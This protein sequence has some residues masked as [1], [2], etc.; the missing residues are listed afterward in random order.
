MDKNNKYFSYWDFAF[1]N[2]KGNVKRLNK[3]YIF[4]I[5]LQIIATFIFWEAAEKVLPSEIRLS[6]DLV[7]KQKIVFSPNSIADYLFIPIWFALSG[8]SFYI[9]NK[10]SSSKP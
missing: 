7:R 2:I 5:F 8:I 9:Y 4:F 3:K 1:F 10:T 6:F